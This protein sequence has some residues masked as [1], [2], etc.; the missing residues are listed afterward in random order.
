MGRLPG[1]RITSS[2]RP[3]LRK[4]AG[5]L[6]VDP[7]A[8][9]ATSHMPLR[10]QRGHS[11]SESRPA[12]R[13]KVLP[14]WKWPGWRASAEGQYDTFLRP[15][16][17]ATLA[18]V[19]VDIARAGRAE[20]PSCGRRSKRPSTRFYITC[21]RRG[22]ARQMRTS[23]SLTTGRTWNSASGGSSGGQSRGWR[24]RLAGHNLGKQVG[25]GQSVFLVGRDTVQL[26]RGAFEA[27][28]AG[29]LCSSTQGGTQSGELRKE[30]SEPK[31]H[32]GSAAVDLEISCE[33]LVKLKPG[34]TGESDGGAAEFLKA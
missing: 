33:A 8:A 23:E 7:Q 11:R 29:I 34:R 24:R 12:A 19:D 2:C 6:D 3:M 21:W 32:P 27:H 13:R 14:W 25:Q 31:A 9:A 30:L 16:R 20:G 5:S 22:R 1:L 26:R 10:L 17:W 15:A 28:W 18:S 4:E